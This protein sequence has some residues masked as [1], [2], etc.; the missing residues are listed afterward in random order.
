MARWHLS[1]NAITDH[2]AGNICERAG[3]IRSGG[4]SAADGCW[5]RAYGK[6]MICA[7]N[8]VAQ[9]AQNWI[10]AAGTL[11]MNGKLGRQALSD[12]FQR[13]LSE[14]VKGVQAEALGH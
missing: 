5:I 11:V 1:S 9:G 8:F 6:R 4:D 10:C 7:E 3:L 12:C 13:F 2:A 14:G